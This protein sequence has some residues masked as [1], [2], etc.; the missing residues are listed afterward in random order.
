M[1]KEALAREFQEAMLERAKMGFH[2]FKTFVSSPLSAQI[3]SSP[4]SA[5]IL[6]H[7]LSS[8]P[9]AL[10]NRTAGTSEGAPPTPA[11]M[12]AIAAY[13]GLDHVS[14]STI[15]HPCLD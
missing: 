12:I 8:P 1:R 14:L 4:L 3:L 6:A 10:V 2:L 7:Q 13:D 5:Q 9:Q 15:T 11:P